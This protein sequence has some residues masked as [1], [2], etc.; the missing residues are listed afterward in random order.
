MCGVGLSMRHGNMIRWFTPYE[1]RVK[2]AGV[3]PSNVVGYTSTG[4]GVRLWLKTPA[5]GRFGVPCLGTHDSPAH[6][7]AIILGRPLQMKRRFGPKTL[8]TE[9]YCGYNNPSQFKVP[10]A[11]LKTT[12]SEWVRDLYWSKKKTSVRRIKAMGLGD[13]VWLNYNVHFDYFC[14]VKIVY[15]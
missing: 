7:T 12:D 10:F 4:P 11:A 5:I 6:A 2:R 8:G 15:I 9:N 1:G 13:T 14:F 3:S